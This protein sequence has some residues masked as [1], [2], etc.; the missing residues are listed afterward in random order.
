VSTNPAF[1][2]LDA[3]AF[4]VAYNVLVDIPL[5]PAPAARVWIAT[6]WPDTSRSG[7]CGRLFSHRHPQGRGWL[8]EPLTHLGDRDG[9]SDS[10]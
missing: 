2:V 7:E 8:I 5:D 9:S 4:R 6:I 1:V 10:D 3:H